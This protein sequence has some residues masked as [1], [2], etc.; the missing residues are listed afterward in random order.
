MLTFFATYGA[1]VF[2]A[3]VILGATGICKYFYNKAK[4]IQKLYNVEEQKA[5]DKNIDKKLQPIY[6]EL[7]EL[8]IALRKD[9]ELEESHMRI[10]LSSYRYR[11]MSLCKQYIKQGYI[12][13]E[14]YDQITE[15]YK[16]YHDLGGNGQAK[17]FYDKV[18]SL[19]VHGDIE[20]EMPHEH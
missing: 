17:E 3:V 10:I 14:Q 8:R 6:E 13:P 16:V 18:M 4:E 2:L 1:E 7:E 12:T 11:L 9:R 5:V 19:Q 20:V 15:F